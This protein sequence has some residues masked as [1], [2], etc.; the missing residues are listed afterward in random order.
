MDSVFDN[1][2]NYNIQTMA[3]CNLFSSFLGFEDVE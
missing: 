2:Y 1:C 3:N